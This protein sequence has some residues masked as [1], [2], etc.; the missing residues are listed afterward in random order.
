[1]VDMAVNNP[2]W[3]EGGIANELLLKIGIEFHL[4]R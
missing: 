3:G 4:E 1:V 2:I